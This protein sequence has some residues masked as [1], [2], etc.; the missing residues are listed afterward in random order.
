VTPFVCEDVCGH[1]EQVALKR[2]SY[3]KNNMK[4]KKSFATSS[5]CACRISTSFCNDLV[6]IM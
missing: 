6:K 1:G 2:T 3:Y 4:K 5:A